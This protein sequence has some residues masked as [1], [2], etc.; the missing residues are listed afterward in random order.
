MNKTIKKLLV[1][2][3]AFTLSMPLTA[4]G[5]K[6]IDPISFDDAHIT[7]AFPEKFNYLYTKSGQLGDNIEDVGIE[8]SELESIIDPEIGS[9]FDAVYL[10]DDGYIIEATMRTDENP[11]NNQSWDDL[12]SKELKALGKK[13]AKTFSQ[14]TGATYIFDDIY[15]SDSDATFLEYNVTD[16]DEGWMSACFFSIVNNYNYFFYV[17]TWNPDGIS[18]QLTLDC[19][20]IVDGITFTFENADTGTITEDDTNDSFWDDFLLRLS[21]NYMITSLIICIPAIF[22][23]IIQAKKNN[24]VRDADCYQLARA[25]IEER[26]ARKEQQTHD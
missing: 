16:S 12:S 14:Q 18:S 11:T 9:Y 8:A 20:D 15:Y 2:S 25:H 3:F 23:R 6:R 4:C 17:T 5:T 10:D 26:K 7:I 24:F 21:R 1:L 19:M 22:I 13:Y